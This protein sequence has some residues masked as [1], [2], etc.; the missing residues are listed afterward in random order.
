[1]LNRLFIIAVAA[2][3]LLPISA[4]AA[5]PDLELRIDPLSGAMRI[6]AVGGSS[7]FALDGYTITSATLA[8][9]IDPG[10]GGWNSLQDQAVSTFVEVVPAGQELLQ[11]SELDFTGFEAVNPGAE[12]SL[13]NAYETTSGI[14]DLTFQYSQAGTVGPTF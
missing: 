11:I 5:V 7:P 9:V 14:E 4:Q 3:W 8:N 13:G 2:V 10:V 1:M 6:V 12:L